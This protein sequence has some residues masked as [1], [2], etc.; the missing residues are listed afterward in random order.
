MK[1]FLTKNVTTKA[2]ECGA[3]HT[4]RAVR[5]IRLT[6]LLITIGELSLCASA[7]AALYTF[8]DAPGGGIGT[9]PDNGTTLDRSITVSG[10]SERVVSDLA[11]QLNISG[12]Y[13]GDIYG[14]LRLDSAGGG[15]GFAVLLNRVGKDG[16]L[17]NGTLNGYSGTGFDIVLSPHGSTD[18]HVYGTGSPSYNGSGQLTGTWQPDGRSDFPGDGDTG[19]NR[20]AQFDSFMGLN[21]NGVWT[22][23]FFDANGNSFDSCLVSWTLDITAVP[24]PVTFALGIFGVLVATGTVGSWLR[25]SARVPTEG[26]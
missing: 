9:I 12:G 6:C 16:T 5:Y 1:I 8:S 7:E 15:T 18:I 10:I 3:L 25:R 21:P 2:P 22:V 11:L 24:E 13:N 26:D 4:L 20:N 23:S 17:Q 14:Y 19:D